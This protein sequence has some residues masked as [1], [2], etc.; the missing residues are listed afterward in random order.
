[1]HLHHGESWS[2]FLLLVF[3]L[4]CVTVSALPSPQPKSA[5]AR[6]ARQRKGMLK[7]LKRWTNATYSPGYSG[8]SCIDNEAAALTAPKSNVWAGLT[9]YEA[10]IVTTWLFAQPELNLTVSDDAGEWDNS[11]L[12]VELMVP[13]KTDVLAYIDGN[14]QMPTRYAHVVLDHRASTD[15]YYAD[16]LVGPLPVQNGTTTW[17]PLEYPYTRKTQGRI[18]NLDADGKWRFW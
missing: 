11:V 12:L 10:A 16:I 14:C 2:T 15:P 6:Q 9:D 8:S 3:G 13:N 18:R 7:G 17:Q 5:W 4:A 1:M